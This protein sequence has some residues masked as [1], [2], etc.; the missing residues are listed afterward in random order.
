M[1]VAYQFVRHADRRGRIINPPPGEVPTIAL[2]SGVY[3]EHAQLLGI[4]I[5]FHR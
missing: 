4:T 2:N 5:T 1:D 3:R